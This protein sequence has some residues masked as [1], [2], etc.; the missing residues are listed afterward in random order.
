MSF[1]SDFL[2]D[3]T[4]E[5]QEDFLDSPRHYGVEIVED[6]SIVDQRRWVTVFTMVGKATD[7]EEFYRFTWERGSTEMQETDG[8]EL[9]FDRVYP[10]VVEKTIYVSELLKEL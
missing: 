9:R 8:P 7:A 4:V 1:I 6:V 2:K 10:K 5:D 3:M